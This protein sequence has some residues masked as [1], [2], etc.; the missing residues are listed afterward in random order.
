M[1]SRYDVMVKMSGYKMFTVEAESISEAEESA[2]AEVAD[3]EGEFDAIVTDISLVEDFDE[4]TYDIDCG[5]NHE[6]DLDLNE[7]DEEEMETEDEVE[8]EEESN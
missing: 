7:D 2:L 3:G 6:D 5:S 4:S 8:Y 1:V